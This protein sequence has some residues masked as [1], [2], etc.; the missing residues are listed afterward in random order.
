[1][2]SQ[3]YL[4]PSQLAQSPTPEALAPLLS[5]LLECPAEQLPTLTE[6]S[7][8]AINDLPADARPRSYEGLLDVARFIVEDEPGW[9]TAERARFVA[10]HPHIGA[11]LQQGAVSDTSKA[12]QLQGG[13]TTP[14][15][16]ARLDKLNK[17]Y[18]LRFPTLRFVTFV[19]GRSRAAVADELAALLGTGITENADIDADK[20][21]TFPQDEIRPVE[22]EEWQDELV[23]AEDALWKIA[24]DRASK[25]SK[26]SPTS[27]PTPAAIASATT[28][29]VESSAQPDEKKV[30]PPSSEST[31]DEP[32]LSLASFRMLVLSSPVLESFFE[33]DLSTSFILEPPERS[34]SGGA[35]AW[36]AAPTPAGAPRAVPGDRKTSIGSVSG[37]SGGV[38]EASYSR[39][40]TT[41]TKGRVVGF[42]GGLLGEEGKAKMTQLADTVAQR[43][44]T[45]TVTGP[46]PSFGRTGGGVT[47]DGRRMDMGEME[48]DERRR[49]EERA[50]EM[51]QERKRGLA[52]RLAGAL[53]G[54]RA[55]VTAATS[56]VGLTSSSTAQAPA[57]A[58]SSTELGRGRPGAP[59]ASGPVSTDAPSELPV[60][61]Q[62]SKQAKRQSLRGTDLSYSGPDGAAA[63]LRQAT[64][65]L[66]DDRSHFVIDEPGLAGEGEA[67]VDLEE[68][69]FGVDVDE[70][71]LRKG[72]SGSSPADAA[73]P[74]LGDSAGGKLEGKAAQLAKD[75]RSA[76]PQ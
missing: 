17:L 58:S 8:A 1:M 62:T 68:D 57:T 13:E 49:K 71:G 22:S 25:L 16:L 75:L 38:V 66:L 7:I 59:P 43:L 39:D 45:H 69:E 3:S 20:P 31:A 24:G 21:D 63:T 64:A 10:G 9:P 11:P 54:A 48:E 27:S 12:E 73:L 14:E 26:Q 76:P 52:G 33:R 60:A 29:V 65:A 2:A 44:Q 6:Q 18:E 51:A 67:E 15:T 70:A 37:S 34:A 5:H 47:L 56:G 23:R 42:L 61:A 74:G 35:Y 4:A 55:Q 41:G 28:P 36:H 32:F 53:Q 19:A 50:R 40:I 30:A 46:K 72:K